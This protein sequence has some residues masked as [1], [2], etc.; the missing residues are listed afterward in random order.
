MTDSWNVS[1]GLTLAAEQ[2]GLDRVGATAQRERRYRVVEV[3]ALAGAEIDRWLEL[4]RGN[5]A[6]D[7][8]YFHPGFA[9]AVAATRAGVRVI[10]EEEPDGTITSFLPVQF[11]GR[12][13]RPAGSPGVDFQGPICV[14]GGRYD[15][16]SALS[17]AG[18]STYEFDHLLD[19]VAGFEPW[20]FSRQESPYLDVTGGI[21][22]YLSRASRSGKDKVAEARRLSRKAEREYGPVRLVAE[23]TD[24]SVLDTLIA[25]KRRQ[26]A[27]TGARDYFSDVRHVELL[28]RLLRTRDADFG[29]LLSAVYAGPDLLAAHF[30]LRAGPVLHWWFPVYDPAFSRLSPG[31]VLLRGVIDA[32]PELGVERIDL[33]R[34]MDDYKRRAMT[35]HQL[36]C[37]GAV[38]ANPVRRRAVLG[39]RRV[40][41][42]AKSSPIAP[43]LRR[44][45]RRTRRRSE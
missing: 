2:S 37:Q 31:W 41:A 42:A 7:S 27:E 21:E 16:T 10:I 35:G 34:G 44:V 36:V 45:V 4:R 14:H 1:G 3:G 6:L 40:L 25:L 11:D 18:A 8:P 13:S 39:R 30:G 23:C 28:H 9:T 22:G 17:A 12:A 29:G 32:A 20:V 38:I 33:G 26:Y 43:A 24:S 15:V 19:G 5:P